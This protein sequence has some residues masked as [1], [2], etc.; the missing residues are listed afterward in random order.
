MINVVFYEAFKEEEGLL[1][2]FLPKEI[3]VKFTSQ[4]IQEKQESICPSDVISLRTQSVIPESWSDQLSGILTRSTGYDHLLAYQEKTKTK[5]ILGYLPDYCARAVAEQAILMMLF[6]LRKTKL[7][8]QNFIHFKRDSITGYECEGKNL[9]VVGVGRIGSQ[10][11]KIGQG[12]GMNVK[13]VD[14]EPK[15]KEM[16]HVELKEGMPWADVVV[17]ALPLTKE[18]RGMLNYDCFRRAER[19]VIFVNISRGEISPTKDLRKLLG[20]GILFGLGMDVY[21]GEKDIAD[22]MRNSKK[23]ADA[24][25]KMI[26]ELEKRDNVIFTPHNAFNTQEAVYKKAEQSIAAIRMFLEKKTFPALVPQE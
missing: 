25:T 9:L 7:Q 8:M 17:C 11:I 24:K 5:A 20:E 21:E 16:E 19:S 15:V 14:I 23:G 12:L 18:T 2:Q 26:L 6:L 10:I 13:G 1:R 4:T 22:N 3:S